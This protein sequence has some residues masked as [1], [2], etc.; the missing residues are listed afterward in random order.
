MYT[1]KNSQHPAELMC[2]SVTLDRLRKLHLMTNRPRLCRVLMCIINLCI[3]L[4]NTEVLK[5]LY[6]ILKRINLP[7][8]FLCQSFR[9]VG[10]KMHKNKKIKKMRT[11]SPRL[12]KHFS[13]WSV[14]K[15]K[16]GVCRVW[17]VWGEK[18]GVTYRKD[19][20][21][22]LNIYIMAIF[23]K[24]W[25]GGR[26]GG[27]YPWLRRVCTDELHFIWIIVMIVSE[28]FEKLKTRW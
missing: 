13:Y 12:F 9:E 15:L 18:E 26:G 10:Q 2:H 17:W 5:A 4:R 21:V 28:I 7:N 8:A 6:C 27:G 24:K 3:P 14:K 19:F 20:T 1:C 23:E 22:I 11:L 16:M 25:R